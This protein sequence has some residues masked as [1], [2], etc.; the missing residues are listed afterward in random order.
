MTLGVFSEATVTEPHIFTFIAEEEKKN[1]V[2][3]TQE[4]AC[5]LYKFLGF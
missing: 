1:Q 4:N 3:P 5:M 2:F